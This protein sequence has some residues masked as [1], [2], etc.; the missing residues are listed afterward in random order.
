MPHGDVEQHESRVV[1]PQPIFLSPLVLPEKERP[2]AMA[3]WASTRA[4]RLLLPVVACCA[5]CRVPTLLL[6]QSSRLHLTPTSHTAH[7]A[8][9]YRV[10]KHDVSRSRRSCSMGSQWGH[11][12]ESGLR[13]ISW[14]GLGCEMVRA[15][16]ERASEMRLKHHENLPSMSVRGIR[17]PREVR[18]SLRLHGSA[19]LEAPRPWRELWGPTKSQ[20]TR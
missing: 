10:E 5:A 3:L 9:P 4:T 7:L 11:E 8:L 17:A 15:R 6:A 19:V 18:A 16:V 13:G 14:R 20:G 12:S 1:E 2:I